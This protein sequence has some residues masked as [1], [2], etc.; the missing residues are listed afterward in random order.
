LNERA[1]FGVEPL[2]AD[3][4]VNTGTKLAPKGDRSPQA[5]FLGR[6]NAAVER[7]PRHHLGMGKMTTRTAHLPNTFV[8][9]M[10][11][12]LQLLH[13]RNLQC[14][15]RLTLDQTAR[16]PLVQRIHQLAINIEL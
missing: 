11:N 10:P 3:L 2:L 4:A 15:A 7:D 6:A 13:E 8:W 16:A 5:K 9:L 12:V 1:Q 14:P